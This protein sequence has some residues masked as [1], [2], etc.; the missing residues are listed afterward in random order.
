MKSFNQLKHKN[1]FYRGFTLLE[2]LVALAIVSI[3]IIPMVSV[4]VSVSS[5]Q[6]TLKSKTFAE[7]VASNKIAE[8]HLDRKFPALGTKK[9]SEI[10]AGREWFW[11]A[12]IVKANSL[13]KN[14][15]RIEVTVYDSEDNDAQALSYVVSLVGKQK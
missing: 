15:R 14:I 1:I 13:F 4:P 9:G 11:E 7:Y 12:K 2:V 3:A 5:I 10:M 8:I 6:G